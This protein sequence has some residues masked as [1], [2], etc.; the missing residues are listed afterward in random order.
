[1]LAS[2]IVRARAQKARIAAVANAQ[3]RRRGHRM[4]PVR[5]I[6]PVAGGMPQ[7]SPAGAGIAAAVCAPMVAAAAA[8]CEQAVAVVAA[9]VGAAA[10]VVVAVGAPTSC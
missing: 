7:I 6:A 3:A 1:M 4:A 9:A 5:V 2:A 10:D 8:A